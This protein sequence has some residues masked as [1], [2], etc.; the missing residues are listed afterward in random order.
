M[1]FASIRLV[2]NDVDALAAFYTRLTGLE[3]E[4]PNP[5]FANFRF[6]QA[7]LAIS[8]EELVKRFNEGAAIGAANRSAM[9]EFEVDDVDGVRARLGES[10]DCAMEPADMPWGNRSMLIRD[11]DGNVVNIFHRPTR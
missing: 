5:A 9:V 8:S 4:R 3:P 6:P 1:N 7:S 2:T 10:V 11:P